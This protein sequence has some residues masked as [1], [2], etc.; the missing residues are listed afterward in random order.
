MFLF[1][2]TNTLNVYN[3][4]ALP[5]VQKLAFFFDQLCFSSFH[6]RNLF[7]RKFSLIFYSHVEDSAYISGITQFFLF[8]FLIFSFRFSS[9]LL[10]FYSP[11]KKHSLG[12]YEWSNAAAWIKRLILW[13]FFR[14]CPFIELNM[15]LKK[16][17]EKEEKFWS[18]SILLRLPSRGGFGL[19]F[20]LSKLSW[21]KFTER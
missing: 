17:S 16:V 20:W 4:F 2:R 7:S 21:G 1:I 11:R 12:T 5:F 9:F 8:F 3:Y 13:I 19:F 15:R 10:F 6:S 18:Y 14:S